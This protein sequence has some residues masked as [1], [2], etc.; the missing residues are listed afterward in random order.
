[1]RNY[2]VVQAFALF[3][4]FTGIQTIASQFMCS[5]LFRITRLMDLDQNLA[6]V[7]FFSFGVAT[8]CI[9]SA[10]AGILSNK[11]RLVIGALFGS[12]C[13]ITQL[14]I[15]C[16]FVLRSFTVKPL[17]FGRDVLFYLVTILWVFR[18]FIIK[19]ELTS[20]DAYGFLAFYV[21][22]VLA[23]FVG[24]RF[25]TADSTDKPLN[26]TCTLPTIE[27]NDNEGEK[28]ESSS[29]SAISKLGRSF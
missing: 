7:T 8:P 16:I 24:S 3:Y 9:F 22:Y 29:S 15:G 12:A 26:H 19:K 27:E 10:I 4:L 23:A 6:G 18:I 14:I 20:F 17:S 13:F 5:S 21:I 2:H 25:E 11:P 1:L 28:V